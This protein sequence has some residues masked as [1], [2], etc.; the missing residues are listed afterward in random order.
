M[1]IKAGSA[2]KS[3]IIR[4]VDS[5][6]GTPEEGVTSITA[7]IALWY[8]RE[9]ATKTAISLSD[10]TALD[11]AH[12]D[13]G[14]LHIDDGYYRLDLPD[15]A[16]AAGVDG[17]QIGGTVTDMVV[18]GTYVQ[19]VGYDPRTELTATRLA[20]LDAAVSSVAAA[21]WA[22][23]TSTLTTAGTI[24]KLIVDKL[25]LITSATNITVNNPVDGGLLTITKA[26]T[27]NTNAIS[28]TVP[29]TWT[30]CY[31]TLKADD[32]DLDAAAIVQ[33]LESNPSDPN[34]GLQYLNGATATTKGDGSITVDEPNDTVAITI[35]D[36]ATA[37]L[38]KAD[39]YSWDVKILQSDGEST[40]PITGTG[41]VQLP[42]TLTI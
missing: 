10:L 27:L 9:G 22:V 34:D 39:G 1:L 7:G 5:T 37:Q 30:K 16:F 6:D 29:S 31:F 35:K 15:A 23:L 21:V 2:D 38:S 40:R 12:S 42:Q 17:V 13:G 19:L 11:D 8:R 32:G 25:G 4:I 28:A 33:I 24:G 18:I 14:I 36:D 41:K 26:V 3:V 20:Y